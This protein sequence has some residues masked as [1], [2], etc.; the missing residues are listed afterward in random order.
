MLWL[1]WLS[2][3]RY[4]WLWR[5]CDSNVETLLRAPLPSAGAKFNAVDF[6]VVDLETTSLQA[7]NGE[8]ASIGWVPITGGAIQLAGAEHHFVTIQSGVGQ[9][10]VIHHIHDSELDQGLPIRVII[11]RLLEVAVGKVLVFHHAGLDMDYLNA[12]SI[13]LYGTPFIVPIVDTLVLER[14]SLS[15]SDSALP[16]GVLRLHSCRQRYG[17]PDYPAH[18]AL[19]DALATA[20]LLL[21]WAASAGGERGVDLVDCI[22]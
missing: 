17:L 5:N 14:R 8:I 2:L 22:S 20:E 10:A 16:A 21:A 6:L 19:T 11:D 12:V 13:K 9:S 18:D 1:W 15:R 4:Y 7:I 3:K